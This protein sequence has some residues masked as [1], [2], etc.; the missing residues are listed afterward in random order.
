MRRILLAFLVLLAM[1]SALI[2][3][4]LFLY[5]GRSQAATTE[6]LLA[7]GD[8]IRVSVYQNPDLMTS[9]RVT[10]SGTITFPL[11]GSVKVGGLA[12]FE[13]EALIAGGLEQRGLVKSPQVSI[14]LQELRGS[15]VVVYGQVNK[16]GRYPLET[17]GMRLSDALALA[18]GIA[19]TGADI[20]VVTGERDGKPFRHEV[21][22]P[23]MYRGDGQN[24]KNMY[25]VGGDTVFVGRAPVFYIYGEVQKPG[26]LRLEREM[27]LMQAVAAGG[28][29]TPRGTLRGVRVNRRDASGKLGEMR[30]NLESGIQENDVIYIRASLF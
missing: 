16:A 5:A 17:T 9:A 6:Y 1:P 12:I 22:I 7:A 20:V 30:M 19:P 18:G 25:M 8:I 15:Q 4:P 13:A 11:L 10:E 2:P 28:G 3:L 27:T 24:D 14:L 29:L 23:S 26:A 21:D